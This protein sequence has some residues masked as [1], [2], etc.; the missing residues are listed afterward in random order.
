M[1]SKLG[2]TWYPKDFIS[3]PDVMCMTS[4]ERGVYRDLI[5]LAYMSGNQISHS[6][7][8]LARYTSSDIE[9][10]QSVLDMKGAK[11]GD[12]WTIPSCEK[13]IKLSENNRKNGSKG[14]R[15]SSES[16][17]NLLQNNK[18]NES[19]SRSE[20]QAKSENTPKRNQSDFRSQRERER[21]REIKREKKEEKEEKENHLPNIDRVRVDDTVTIDF[22]IEYLKSDRTQSWREYLAM[23][24]RKPMDELLALLDEFSNHAKNQGQFEKTIKDCQIHFGHWITKKLSVSLQNEITENALSNEHQPPD[25]SGKWVWSNAKWRDKTQMTP[26]QLRAI[27]AK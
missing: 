19:E 20:M 23:N 21:E 9:T 22:A 7:E 13:R 6:M 27:A 16:E 4:S 1:A 18:R 10:V 25:N 11:I 26:A 8:K 17:A 24:H 12:F 14:G 2:Y 15:N 3:D 5:D